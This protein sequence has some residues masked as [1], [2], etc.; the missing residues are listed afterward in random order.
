LYGLYQPDSGAIL[1][2]GKS[3]H[4]RS[5]RDAIGRGI[6]MVHQHFM[7]VPALTVVENII[8]GAEPSRFG[9]IDLPKARAEVENTCRRFG[10]KLDTGARVEDL[11][12][13]SQ[14]KVEIVKALHRG[15]KVLILDE[16][17]AVLTPQEAEEL[18]AVV[19]Q[20]SQSG[21]S[22]VFI[23]HKLKEVL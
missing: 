22:I 14:Q 9:L 2:D 5:P 12:V 21:H 6:G 13:G 4:L 1:I 15:A 8:L 20:L 7:L 19:R 17:T 18:F 11:S 23:S 3:V 10:F 16:P